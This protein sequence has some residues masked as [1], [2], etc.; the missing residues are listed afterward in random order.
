MTALNDPRVT[1][2]GEGFD[3]RTSLGH[4]HVGLNRRL[5]WSVSDVHTGLPAASTALMS[6]EAACSSHETAGR[7]VAAVLDCDSAEVER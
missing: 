5:L 7:A 2:H 6:N 4:F 1:S 3:V